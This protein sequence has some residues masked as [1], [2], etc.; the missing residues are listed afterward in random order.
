MTKD[1]V[2]G[3]YA[4]ESLTTGMYNDPLILYREYIQNA[5]DS[6]DEA[7]DKGLITPTETQITVTLNPLKRQVTIQD[8]GMGIPLLRAYSSL[9]DIGNSQKINS[10]SRGFRGIGRFCG[11]SYCEKLTFV[12]SAP[13]EDTVYHI[14]FDAAKLRKIIAEES[15]VISASEAILST[16]AEKV[17]KGPANAHYFRVVMDGV[18]SE[19]GLLD[20][21]AVKK[22][23]RTVAP[24]D[25]DKSFS[26]RQTI[27]GRIQKDLGVLSVYNI[28]LITPDG[29]TEITKPYSD[30]ILLNRQTGATDAISD[31][32]FFP[33]ADQD[34]QMIG[35]AWYGVSGFLG[36]IVGTDVKSLRLRS[37]NILIGDHTTLNSVFRDSRFNGW[38]VGEV[39]LKSPSLIPNA[40]RDGFEH[41]DL[42]YHMMEQLRMLALEIVKSIR[43]S[44]AKRYKAI[45]EAKAEEEKSRMLLED[46]GLSSTNKEKQQKA[47]L[48]IRTQLADKRSSL[49]IADELRQ[50]ALDE[51]DILSGRIKEG[52]SYT[53]INMLT[54]LNL[55]EKQLLERI[56][57]GLEQQ[58]KESAEI[59]MEKILKA[60]NQEW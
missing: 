28:A 9:S 12:T 11:L 21:D 3:K 35:E 10:E 19:T 59:C 4:I 55:Q 48:S 31:I 14:S 45:G 54:R 20:V 56:F 39:I 2:I 44:S 15:E 37:G 5:A 34:G 47:L 42:Y 50:E 17:V 1:L 41:N 36:T 13:G 26:W 53:A 40:R 43:N 7:I 52:T 8:N 23:L 38:V 32:A 51:L 49:E 30:Q 33:L 27:L 29:K 18:Q 60:L 22:Y 58:D 16:I 25:F 46:S 57:R 24:V 6:L